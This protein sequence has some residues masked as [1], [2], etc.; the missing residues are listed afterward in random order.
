MR[1]ET[2]GCRKNDR[3]QDHIFRLQQ[4]TGKALYKYNKLY[5][6]SFMHMKKVFDTKKREYIYIVVPVKDN[7]RNSN[8]CNL[9][10]QTKWENTMRSL[11]RS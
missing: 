8:R 4:L 6:V 11:N 9:R 3:V 7:Q 2:S 5:N 10:S 1:Q